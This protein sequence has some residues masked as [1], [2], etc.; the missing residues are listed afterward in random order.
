MKDEYTKLYLAYSG[1][2]LRK[3]KH[4]QHETG[5]VKENPKI[6]FINYATLDRL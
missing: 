6:A 4:S 2:I 1:V 3:N 5:V